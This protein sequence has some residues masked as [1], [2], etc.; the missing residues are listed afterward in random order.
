[1]P[2]REVEVVEYLRADETLGELAPGGI[3]ADSDLTE[4]GITDPAT[5]PDV[6]LDGVFQTTIRVHQRAPV[7]TGDLQSIATQ[8]TSM[9]Q[10]IEVWGYGTPAAIEAALNQVYALMM[11]K[12]FTAAFSATW[13][14]SGPGIM[15][16]PGL[17]PGIRTRHEDYRI[18]TIRRPVTA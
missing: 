1:M 14:G 3:Y 5:T 13:A 11:G 2:T 18:V 15:Q 17:S 7:P 6:Y 9:S 12:R 8:R 10:V 4:I 16:A